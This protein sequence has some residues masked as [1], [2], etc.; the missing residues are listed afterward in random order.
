VYRVYY[1]SNGYVASAVHCGHAP[2]DS[3]R[4]VLGSVDFN[5]R[6]MAGEAYE[7]NFATIAHEIGHVIG[8]SSSFF[9]T[10]LVD[11]KYLA[12]P[13]VLEQVREHY[14]CADAKGLLIE[15]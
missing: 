1:A 14:D 4:P 10:W 12:S 9:G 13:K 8:I 2:W 3:G 11:G 6:Y 7:N 15:Q 5:L